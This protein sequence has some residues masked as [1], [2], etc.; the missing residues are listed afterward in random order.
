MPVEIVYLLL[1]TLV[2]GGFLLTIRRASKKQLQGGP[3]AESK[4]D[5]PDDT[6]NIPAETEGEPEH[7]EAQTLRS[8]LEKTRGGFVA[9]LSRLLSR[10][11]IDTD[12]LEQL[13]QVLLT[14][15]IGPRTA[16]A[17][18]STIK[19][20]LTRS[21]LTDS[22]V[23]WEKIRTHSADILSVDAPPIRMDE[24]QP[25]VLL[26]IGVN[27]VGKTTTIGKLATKFTSNGRKVLLAAGDTFR[28][29]AV[30]Q[31]E[32]WGKRANCPVIKGEANSDPSAVI[33]DGIKRATQE[34][35]D[36]VIADTAGRLHTKKKSHGRTRENR[37]CLRQSDAQ[38]SSRN[39]A[40]PR[41]YDRAECHPTGTTISTGHGNH[42]HRAHKTGRDSQGR[43]NSRYL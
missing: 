39:L 18:F 10:K 40:R 43:G 37:P 7:I 35:Y 41:C 1:T 27:G 5:T 6:D 29:A 11:Q 12:I 30:E 26:V 14:A 28:A 42:G 8:G 32:I 21:E 20:E 34:N 13:E 22:R 17:L 36:I 33:F 19:S 38:R 15:D 16:D 31:L 2:V 4:P 3:D 9:K 24:H 25:F 23:V